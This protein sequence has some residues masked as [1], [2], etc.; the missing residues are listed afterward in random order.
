[1]IFKMK[2]CHFKGYY[3]FFFFNHFLK[4]MLKSIPNYN[5]STKRLFSFNEKQKIQYCPCIPPVSKN[6]T[7]DS[8]CLTK[9][10]Y[11]LKRRKYIPPKAFDYFQLQSHMFD[12]DQNT[13]IKVKKIRFELLKKNILK[14]L[15]FSAN[16]ISYIASKMSHYISYMEIDD[17]ES[18]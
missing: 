10:R 18:P 13:S 9:V 7:P 12:S 16:Y 2:C 8:N 4:F 6:S 1:M 11:N 15:E 14:E 17:D 3:C 5:T